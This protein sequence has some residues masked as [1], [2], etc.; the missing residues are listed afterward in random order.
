MKKSFIKEH[1]GG[2]N[3]LITVAE[4]SDALLISKKTVYRMIK[5]NKVDSI[6]LGG[7]YAIKTSSAKKLIKGGI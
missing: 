2:K 6:K 3:D 7:Y 5:N 1:L 4:L